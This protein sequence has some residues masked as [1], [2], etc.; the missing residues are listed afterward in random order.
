MFEVCKLTQLLVLIILTCVD[1]SALMV[2]TFIFRNKIPVRNLNESVHFSE[3][4]QLLQIQ[5]MIFLII[6][7]K[8]VVPENI[9]TPTTE[10]IGNS[11]GEGGS[12][13]QEIPGGGGL[14]NQFSF[15]RSFDS[16][17]I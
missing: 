16:I 11:E 9:H 3:H 7:L 2:Q 10:G 14:Y 4:N 8:C 12:K 17:R 6:F 1:F 13:T 15:Q 5:F